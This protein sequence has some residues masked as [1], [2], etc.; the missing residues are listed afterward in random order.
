METK[1]LKTAHESFPTIFKE[2]LALQLEANYRKNVETI[3]TEIKRRLDYLQE[4]EATKQRFERD[5]L[6]K[7]IN[8]GVKF[9]TCV[10]NYF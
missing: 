10:L 6:L 1:S 8:E 4:V 7:S 9:S 3:S 2:N 5:I